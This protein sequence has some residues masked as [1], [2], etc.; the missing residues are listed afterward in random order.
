M[1]ELPPIVQGHKCYEIT[2]AE[3]RINLKSILER[4]ENLGQIFV[5]T[6]YGKPFATLGHLPTDMPLKVSGVAVVADHLSVPV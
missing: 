4:S 5:V 6:D 2:I 1:R 3:L